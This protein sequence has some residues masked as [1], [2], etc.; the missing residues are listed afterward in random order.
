MKFTVSAGEE[1]ITVRMKDRKKPENPPDKTGK[2]SD[3]TVILHK[4]DGVTM[5]GLPGAEFAIYHGDRAYPPNLRYF[6]YLLKAYFFVQGSGYI[7]LIRFCNLIS[8]G[9]MNYQ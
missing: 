6:S 3:L 1:K 5:K 9:I 8:A 7:L 2:D 4:Y